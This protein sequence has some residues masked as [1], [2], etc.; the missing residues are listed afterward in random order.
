[1]VSACSVSFVTQRFLTL[2]NTTQ[3][4]SVVLCDLLKIQYNQVLGKQNFDDDDT[5]KQKRVGTRK[6][7]PHPE[8]GAKICRNHASKDPDSS[9]K[10]NIQRTTRLITTG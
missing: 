8:A 7:D 4:I 6:C 10:R 2:K 1:M 9:T 5:R 3:N